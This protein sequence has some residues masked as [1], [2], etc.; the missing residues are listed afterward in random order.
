LGEKYGGEVIPAQE[1]KHAMS[2]VNGFL[3]VEKN[4]QNKLI[5]LDFILKVV[6]EDL[7][8]DLLSYIFYSKT[9]FSRQLTYPFPLHYSDRQGVSH[10]LKQKE[11]IDV[12]LAHDCVLVLP[13]RRDRLYKQITNLFHN[14]F[15]YDSRN[16]KAYYYPYVSLC[17]VYNGNHSIASG[18]V[19]KK[20]SIKAERYDITELFPHIYTDGQSWY[21]THTN[22]KAGDVTDFRISIIYEIA[23]AKHQLEKS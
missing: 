11:A 6:K 23:K 1:F 8:T 2:F 7:K 4:I 20:G 16:H 10:S 9:D 17:Y 5:T 18:V 19:H 15:S 13:W 14:N 21:N 12:D 3:E 22:E